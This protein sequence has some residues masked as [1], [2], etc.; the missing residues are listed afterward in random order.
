[1][2]KVVICIPTYKR[3]E[4]LKELILSI[5]A[6]RIDRSVINDLSIIVVD[7]DEQ[8]SAAQVVRELTAKLQEL[9]KITYFNYPIKGLSN[10]RNELLRRAFSINP[11]F[12]VFVD[13]D[14]IVTEEWLNEMVKAIIRN[15]GDMVMGPVVPSPADKISNPLSCWIERP[16]YADNTRLN[17]IR[18][19]NLIINARSLMEKG[20]WFDERF[21]FTGGEDSYFGIQMIRKGATIYW[22]AGAI[23]YETIQEDRAN[24]KWLLR[25]YYN[26]AN[27]YTRILILDKQYFK[28]I[29]KIL[30]SLFYIIAGIFTAAFSLIPGRK[31]Y[32]GLLKLSEGFGSIAGLFMIKYEEYNS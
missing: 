17:F 8:M 18:T 2:N 20:I 29:K 10:V 25:R 32:W 26:G 3:P 24:I 27:I 1:M 11:D 6:G 14:E 28:L 30:V 16:S 15:N 22:A 19:G 31:R 21:N 7:N 23:V 9:I 13:D 5:A 4:M 12:I